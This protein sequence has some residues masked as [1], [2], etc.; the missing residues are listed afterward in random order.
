MM[1]QESARIPVAQR[2]QFGYGIESMP[3]VFVIMTALWLTRQSQ[4]TTH[5]SGGSFGSH[6]SA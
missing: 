4:S 5:E 1:S 3:L 6:A 2:S